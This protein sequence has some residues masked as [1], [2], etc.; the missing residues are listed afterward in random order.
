[1]ETIFITPTAVLRPAYY[2]KLY[3]DDGTSYLRMDDILSPMLLNNHP[4]VIKVELYKNSNSN[5][6]RPTLLATMNSAGKITMIAQLIT[7]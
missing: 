7:K 4:G 1:M 6:V 5:K 3:K 2:T